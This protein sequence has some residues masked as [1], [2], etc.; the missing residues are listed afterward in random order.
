MKLTW[1][2]AAVMALLGVTLLYRATRRRHIDKA[3][4][5]V[6]SGG[7]PGSIRITVEEK[8]AMAEYEVGSAADFLVYESSLAWEVGPLSRSD[9]KARIVAALKAWSNAGGSKLDIA[10]DA[11]QS[12][13]SKRIRPAGSSGR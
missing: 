2:A 5:C 6:V 1:I 10:N 3:F 9:E 7:N 12:A 11:Q 8:V 13:P 4:G